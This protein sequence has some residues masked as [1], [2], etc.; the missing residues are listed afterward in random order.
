M[1]GMI[2]VTALQVFPRGKSAYVATLLLAGQ[3]TAAKSR[4]LGEVRIRSGR[5]WQVQSHRMGLL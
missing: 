5:F 4:L 2:H 1:S 3:V